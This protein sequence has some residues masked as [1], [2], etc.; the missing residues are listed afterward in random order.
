MFVLL[1][2]RTEVVLNL[3]PLITFLNFIFRYG[4]PDPELRNDYDMSI[5]L[6]MSAVQYVHTKRFQSELM[7]FVNHFSQIQESLRRMR[8]VAA[9]N[10]VRRGKVGGEGGIYTLMYIAK[11]K[12]S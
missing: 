7:A 3:V 2:N 8:T 6:R 9:G 12:N 5:K 4:D 1:I 11:Y 10:K